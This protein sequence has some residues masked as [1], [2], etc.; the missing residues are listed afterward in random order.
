MAS[1]ALLVGVL[2]SAAAPD[3]VRPCETRAQ[4]AGGV[5]VSVRDIRIGPA[6][7][8]GLRHPERQRIVG[9]HGRDSGY[10]IPV[11]V[12][13]GRPVLLQIPPRASGRLGL[14]YGTK[15]V[16]RIENAQ[17]VVLLKPCPAGMGRW[18]WFPGGL[19][20]PKPGCY[21]IEVA[22][23]GKPF[24]RRNVALGKRC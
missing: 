24:V 3:A 9:T 19:I 1:V 2:F 12:R 8:L 4:G 20:V 22:R 18:T 11:A 15:N 14:N 23:R 7:F 17:S 6:V 21:P 5:T 16:D 13:A 10:K